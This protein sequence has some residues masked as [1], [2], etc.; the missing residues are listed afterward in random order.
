MNH[1]QKIIRNKRSDDLNFV[2]FHHLNTTLSD[3]FTW[4]LNCFSGISGL[5][6]NYFLKSLV[7][8]KL[9]KNK[10]FDLKKVKI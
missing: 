1:D 8:Y 5:L 3:K 7:K 4:F 2:F 10:V 6:F 9:L